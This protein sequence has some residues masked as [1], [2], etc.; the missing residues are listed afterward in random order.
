M[1]FKITGKAFLFFTV[2]SCNHVYSE[3]RYERITPSSYLQSLSKKRYDSP[4]THKKRKC[5]KYINTI[6]IYA[7]KNNLPEKLIVGLIDAESGFNSKALSAVGAK[8]LMQLMDFNSKSF[9]IDPYNAEE[10]IKVGTFMLAR[11]INKY[12]STSLALAAYNAGEG[13]VNKYNGIPPYKETK[14]YV[15]KIIKNVHGDYALFSACRK[16]F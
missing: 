7:H 12:H 4:F 6:R 11:L 10:N 16:P 8:G 13:A 3:G 14:N 5:Q 9:S 1:T 15:N 2:L